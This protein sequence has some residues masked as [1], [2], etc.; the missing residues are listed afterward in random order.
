MSWPVAAQAAAL[1]L[2]PHLYLSVVAVFLEY[3]QRLGIICLEESLASYSFSTM[4][5]AQGHR[6]VTASDKLKLSVCASQ[7]PASPS[8][9]HEPAR[10]EYK[11]PMHTPFT[12]RKSCLDFQHRRRTSSRHNR[13]HSCCCCCCCCHS[14]CCLHHPSHCLCSHLQSCCCCCS[15]SKA[16]LHCC[17][18]AGH[19]LRLCTHELAESA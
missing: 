12:L 9:L 11:Q 10:R 13:H 18:F 5:L 7:A 1:T 3:L 6:Q 2:L 19:S 14:Q 16:R 15:A 17:P 8:V 4:D